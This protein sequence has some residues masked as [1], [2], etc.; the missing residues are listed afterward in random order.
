MSYIKC[1][2]CNKLNNSIRAACY[3]CHNQLPPAEI[4]PIS[5]WERPV[6]LPVFSLKFQQIHPIAKLSGVILVAFV[7]MSF[8]ASAIRTTEAD[9]SAASH[10]A[11]ILKNFDDYWAAQEQSNSALVA[12]T[13]IA[14]G[15]MK[16]QSGKDALQTYVDYARIQKSRQR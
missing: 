5:A 2:A 11:G 16:T 8:V 9:N 6:V 10:D 3:G 7:L 1:P 4:K 13:N 15:Q 12:C 14:N